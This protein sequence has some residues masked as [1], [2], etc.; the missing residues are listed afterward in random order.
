MD[1]RGI[2]LRTTYYLEHSSLSE[3]VLVL[4]WNCLA[5]PPSPPPPFFAVSLYE[6]VG[7]RWDVPLPTFPPL[8]S[9]SSSSS[10]S[11]SRPLQQNDIYLHHDQ[12]QLRVT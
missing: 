9:S 1:A 2:F 8:L 11:S 4:A 3:N 5:S 6:Y 12:W 10:S 7:E